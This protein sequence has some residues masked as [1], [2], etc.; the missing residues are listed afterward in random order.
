[1]SFHYLEQIRQTNPLIHCITNYVAANFTAN[2]LLAIGASPLMSANVAEVA[3]IQQFA[4]GLLLNIGTPNGPENIEAMILAGKAANQV[5]IPVVLDPVGSG[6]TSYRRQV[7]EK[8]LSEIKFAL[9]RGNAGEIAPL[10]QIQWRSKGVDAGAGEAD[11]AEVAKQVAQQYHC[12][13]AI[14]GETDFVSDGQR[15]AK[16]QNGTPLFPKITGSGCL[17]GAVCGAFLSVA[18]A[19]AY[20]D[21]VVEAATVYAVA[22]EF[23][24]RTLNRTQTG[25]FAVKFLDQLAEINMT[26]AEQQGRVIYA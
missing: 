13:V 2:G 1:M 23:A 6:A 5:G 19:S 22:G 4:K 14:S 12:I 10:A 9:I 15:V 18:P 26:L 7:V 21:A 17:L 20:F 11:L 8:L 25:A 16:V 24:A 3:E